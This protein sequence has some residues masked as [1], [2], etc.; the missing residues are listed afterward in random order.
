VSLK[1]V[2]KLLCWRRGRAANRAERWRSSG[3]RQRMPDGRTCGADVVEPPAGDERLNAGAVVQQLGILVYSS[4]TGTLEPSRGNIDVSVGKVYNWL[5]QAS[6]CKSLCINRDSPWSYFR[7][8]LMSLATAFSI[9]DDC[10]FM[11]IRY[12]N[13]LSLSLIII[14]ID[15]E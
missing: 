5:A 9:R 4:P 13:S 6:Q 11:A 10:Y 14:I 7:V 8:S 15:I 2:C 1:V 3:Q 12:T